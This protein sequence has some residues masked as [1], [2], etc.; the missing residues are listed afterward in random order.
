MLEQLDQWDRALFLL[1]NGCRADWLDKP[2]FAIS[3][4]RFSVWWFLIIFFLIYRKADW[5]YLLLSLVG[6][7][8]VI[9]LCDR[10]SVELFKEVFERFRPTHQPDLEGLVHTVKGWDG[11]YYNGGKF[12]F[13]SSH[14]ANYFGMG[15]F[16]Y[17]LLKPSRR[18]FIFI[19]T[20]VAVVAYS[21]IYLGVHYPGDILG[22]SLLGILVG[23]TVYF[24]FSRVER[25]LPW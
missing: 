21:R 23:Y 3:D 25:R 22:G 10:I 20:W 24:I 14:A 1:L 7:G 19:F 16:F 11:K 17:L 12:G 15:T 4:P 5:K 8:L 2:M 13:V 9:T 6:M 18:I